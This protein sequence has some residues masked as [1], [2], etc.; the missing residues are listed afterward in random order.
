VETLDSMC[1]RGVREF[2]EEPLSFCFA[3]NGIIFFYKA[4]GTL[5]D[6]TAN[7]V[8][9][10]GS[11]GSIAKTLTGIVTMM[12]QERGV[13]DIDKPLDEFIPVFKERG[14]PNELTLH[15]F[16]THMSGVPLNTHHLVDLEEIVADESPS[17]MPMKP[18]YSES[19]YQFVGC[20][21]E[22]VTG[23]DVRHLFQNF[24]FNPMQLMHSYSTSANG[25]GWM[26]P[27][28]LAEVGQM[29]LNKGSYGNVQLMRP[30]TFEQML[31][32]DKWGPRGGVGLVSLGGNGLP[33][34]TFGYTTHH[35]GVFRMVPEEKLVIVVS[36][37]SALHFDFRNKY[38]GR[39][40]KI[41]MKGIATSDQQ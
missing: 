41:I 5:P 30:E 37:A 14:N 8:D 28:E 25:V 33:R 40:F 38:E 39:L 21:L 16:L 22:D 4:Y 27:L 9:R 32:T 10:A 11:L 19:G 24:I 15:H 29:L 12:L 31:P 23:Q 7:T 6:G 13:I 3:R 35:S 34:D 36:S 18:T 26:P 17:L 2:P 20:I 1:S